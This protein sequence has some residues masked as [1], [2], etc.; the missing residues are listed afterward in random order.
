MNTN[1]IEDI[2]PLSPMQQ[3][4]L[5]HSLY[6]PQAG[7]YVEQMSCRL[8]GELDRTAFRKAWQEVLNRHT[9]LRTAFVWEGLAEPLQVVQPQVELPLVE[10]DWRALPPAEQKA[11]LADYRQ[12]ERRRG[13]DP[14]VAPL[15]R[16]ALIRLAD[17]VHH[18]VWT[19]HHILFD[20]WCLPLLL[21][22]V[23]LG[24]EAF[25]RG[26]QLHLPQPRPYRDYIAWLQAQDAAAAGA[27]WRKYLA[28]F[29]APTP[30]R[31]DRAPAANGLTG[32]YAKAERHLPVELT[33][34][35]QALARQQQLTLGTLVQAAWAILLGRCSGENDVVFGLTVS[36][37]PP[38]LAG[39][40]NMIGLF[41]NTL[42]VRVRLASRDS[43]LALLRTLQQ[44]QTELR[45][46]EYSPLVQVQGCSEV[47]RGL[48][49]FESILVFEN[50]PVAAA[51]LPHAG[52]LELGELESES[53]T[54]YP[55]TVVASPG[56]RLLLEAAY[57][58]RRFEHATIERLLGHLHV[59]LEQ[60][61]A[62][63]TQ[64]LS[65]LTLLAPAEKQQLLVEW[66]Q[67]RRDF[68]AEA[69]LTQLF[70]AQV[71]ATPA[72]VAVIFENQQLSYRELDR[73]AEAVAHHLRRRGVGP[74]TVIG[75]CL[76]R[77]AE[78]IIA[79]LGI[80]K[81]GAAY[82]P[83][84]PGLPAE[85]LNFMLADARAP[86]VLTRQRLAAAFAQ[87]PAQIIFLDA[88]SPIFEETAAPPLPAL[89]PDNLAYVIYT[90]GSTGVPKGVAVSHRN[91]VN[92]ACW[93]R[94]FLGLT[95][96]DRVLQFI[97]LGFDASVEEIF[98]TLLGGAALVLPASPL[99]ATPA[100]MLEFC[101][102]H[103]ITVLHLPAAYWHQWVETLMPQ[104]A[105]V[106]ARLRLL[107]VGG[108]SP[109]PEK[110]A[111]WVQAAAAPLRCYNAYGPTETTVTATILEMHPSA[112]PATL[113][114]I[115]RPIANV[116]AYV[117][118]ADLQPLPAGVAGELY[119][120]GA[121]V[122]RGYL[123]RPDLTAEKFI[124]HPFSREPG[125]RLYKSG[126]LARWRP[127]GRLEFLG[128][129]DQQVKVRGFRIEPGEIETCLQQHP[130]VREA[131][132][133]A[134][135]GNGDDSAAADKRL[136][137]YLVP[138][139]GSTLTVSELHEF[140]KARLPEYML[141]A[142]FVLME[143]LPM[144][145]SGKVD[146]HAL[147]A[148]D[149]ESLRL[150]AGTAYVAPRTPTEELL[151][152]LW[153]D[154]LGVLRAGIH[155]NFFTLGGHSL[156]ATQLVSRI[157]ET[158]Q[159][160]LP[161]ADLFE[162]PELA[163]LAA[164]LDNL[165][166]A[167]QQVPV[168]PLMPLPRADGA[169]LPL[170]F[171]QQRLWFLDQLQPGGAFYN[172][173]TALR[174]NGKLERAALTAALNKIVRRHETLRTTFASRDGRPVQIIAPATV[175]TIPLVD[176]TAL[177]AGQS[178]QEVRRLAADEARQPFDLA[179]G[180][181]WRCRLLRLG[182]Q[183]HVLLLTL[184]HIIADG[185]SM[186]VLVQEVAQAYAAALAGKEPGLP[187]LPIQYADYAAWQ[188]QWL[189]GERLEQQLAYWKEQLA[190]HIDA[191]E[192]PTD[193]PRPPLQTFHGASQRIVLPGELARALQTLSQREGVTLFMTLLAAF[194]TLLHRYTG[195]PDILVGSPIANRTRAETENLIGFFVNT[196]VLRA[197]FSGN[198][199][200]RELLRQVRERCLGAYAHQDLPFEKLVEELQ[201]VRDLSRSPLFQ[202]MFV[203][204]N[205]PLRP[206][207]LA[208]VQFRSLE[209]E[210]KT[211]SFDMTLIVMESGDGLAAEL[212]Y[213][214]DLF[215]AETITRLLGHFETLLQGI[216]RE[217]EQRVSYLPLLPAAE[218]RQL[219]V[220]WNA[221]AK[222]FP[223]K[224]CVHQWFEAEVAQ[225]P[226]S[227]ALRFGEELLSYHELNRRA[228]QLARHLR[229]R[230]IGP[231]T[232]VGICMERSLE[233]VIAMLATLKA[234]GAFVPIDPAYP[235]ERVA[236]MLVDSGIRVLLT[237]QFLLG[238][239]PPHPAQVVC[240]DRDWPQIAV[241]SGGN[242]P[243]VTMPENLAYVIY[244]SGSTGRPKGTMLGHRGLCNLAAAQREAFGIDGSSR[245][246]QFS[247]LS[248]DASVWETVMALLN[249]GTLCL[250]SREQLATGQGLLAALREDEIT[251]VT[252]PPSVLAVLPEEGL[253]H[254]QVLITAGEKC[255][256]EL[257][258]RWGRG[259]RY[260]NAYGPTE[261][262]V[263][264]SMLAVR[265]HYPQGPPIGRPL[266]NF[267]LYV[268]DAHLQPVP[269][270]VPGELCVG[271]VGLARGY[272]QRPDLTAEKF[273]P[274]PFSQARGARL[275][276]TGDLVRYLPDGNL[277]FLGRID[278]QVKV[279]GFRIELGEI[280]A[281]LSAH[282]AVRDVAVVVREDIAEDKRIVA[283]VVT[284]GSEEISAAEWRRYCREHLPEYMVPAVFV[285]LAAMP[286]SPSGKI[287]RRALPAPERGRR[288]LAAEYVA[289]RT[290]VEAKLAA[291]AAELLGV[292]RV[293]I[294]DNFFELG[295]HSL[296]A[297]QFMSR[298]RDEFA[299]EVPL[300]SLFEGP[301]VAEL[302]KAVEQV[303]SSAPAQAPAITRVAR[304][305]RR[306]KR[307]S[308]SGEVAK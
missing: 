175:V 14:T 216:A 114:P 190:G 68:P 2:Y 81:S 299:V 149:D 178:E 105:M 231:E 31:L 294:H 290:E 20:G 85:R 35:L 198:P 188:R 82:L 167:A 47:P 16:L 112:E 202:V 209:V 211:A 192:L 84:D 131:V 171:A 285:R 109:S 65:T 140:L 165:R 206:F 168:P 121:G 71:A 227:P 39:V 307:S 7:V 253:P 94:D 77:S 4:M 181:L 205:V 158:F 69:T 235:A 54:N 226:D 15:M 254:L 258:E 298:L 135:A 28:G 148:P 195:Q 153:C 49:L 48:P 127:D 139:P 111:A 250:A 208:G 95:A 34:A 197:D 279:R 196:L 305:T 27:F 172:I 217:A 51:V 63:P 67:T 283:Y 249:G 228:N 106:P 64:P 291:L 296:L 60:M 50:Y 120:G 263:C 257:V 233:M 155:D 189:S 57:E 41:I 244:T 97:S 260:F 59:V 32:G 212:E 62:D 70:A 151:A 40:E 11:R 38:E 247:S 8:H 119:L 180:P 234:G 144:L 161:L 275:Y 107:V 89:T 6:A 182:P 265:E 79:L 236:Y 238:Q 264:A 281:V 184:H 66:N 3:G 251:T 37:R 199:T 271:G 92:H 259:R 87:T 80:L 33:T 280:E 43:L 287:D 24:Y 303:R 113:I 224:L 141:P 169:E 116:Q 284:R 286:L 270:G 221:T 46:Y 219:L 125:A 213:N 45:Q 240:L 136:L 102:H 91:V 132:V 248:F 179:A 177:P 183:E 242:L 145:A 301:T 118:D 282:P 137:A 143:K 215:N 170:S 223:D 191:L 78:M 103:D 101:N 232:L 241:E 10:L 108:E 36:G 53:R 99:H 104:G 130:A 21:K 230:G 5:F 186:G 129:A 229:G 225:H 187:D 58:T 204:Q 157:R 255:T 268:L 154:V 243:N 73:R 90:S 29:S 194:Q 292:E 61:A 115:G 277:E 262:T 22:E 222:A 74:E 75:L 83:L 23:F 207:E 214:T 86:I 160:E 19:H 133:V 117:L 30:L 306:V 272:L 308:L 293:G 26:Q 288:D 110:L 17:T 42:P 134:R 100:E 159:I 126:D 124:P 9:I 166:A 1:A 266:P 276:R 273:V 295:G 246:L 289:P 93:A 156:L 302:A 72:A 13:F 96:A 88:D 174:I 261:T 218:A 278:S 210:T 185:W 150:G 12:E 162:R 138:R 18:F 267:Q 122:T 220:E 76:P 146:R 300:R 164:H 142:A 201:P 56:R 123:N 269:L 200:F 55:L 252:L 297:T 152:N 256:A 163:A 193:R 147:P 274:D 98:P 128:R 245:V 52:S 203:M 44:Q 173:P 25:R 304:E 237:Q 176:L 239:L